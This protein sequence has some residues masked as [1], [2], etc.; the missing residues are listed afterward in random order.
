MKRDTHVLNTLNRLSFSAGPMGRT[1]WMIL[2]VAF[3]IMGGSLLWD[4]YHR[5][6][7]TQK[8]TQQWFSAEC[9]VSTV[10]V[11]TLY[12]EHTVGRTGKVRRAYYRPEAACSYEISDH[13]MSPENSTLTYT[14]PINEEFS[15]E[16]QAKTWL[17]QHYVLAMLLIIYYNPDQPQQALLQSEMRSWPQSIPVGLM[18]CALFLFGGVMVA[19]YFGNPRQK[20]A[21]H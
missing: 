8:S 15:S 4:A 12:R 14:I 11:R 13:A 18:G 16:N 17:D 9:R 1:W 10:Y 5:I 2:A 21:H 19:A 6:A 3:I 7:L 20:N